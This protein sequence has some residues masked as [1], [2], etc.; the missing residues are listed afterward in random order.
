MLVPYIIVS[1][2]VVVLEVSKT[3]GNGVSDRAVAECDRKRLC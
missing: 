1:S 2:R 3:M